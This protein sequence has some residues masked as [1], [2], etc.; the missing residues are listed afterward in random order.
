MKAAAG[1]GLK[2]AVD[3]SHQLL[4]KAVQHSRHS[5]GGL[6][7]VRAGRVTSAHNF[8]Q[9]QLQRRRQTG[10]GALPIPRV[11]VTVKRV[12]CLRCCCVRWKRVGHDDE[13]RRIAVGYRGKEFCQV[14]VFGGEAA[15]KQ[16]RRGR[17]SALAEP[18]RL[19]RRG[20]GRIGG[21]SS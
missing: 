16:G 5:V 18:P 17:E 2:F 21:C 4:K 7:V 6:G 1:V 12:G 19:L 8:V 9:Q 3:V 11:S 15:A 13:R 10:Q 20:A 14:A